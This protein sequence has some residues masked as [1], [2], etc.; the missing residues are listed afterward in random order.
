MKHDY[1]PPWNPNVV[2]W[3]TDRDEDG[4]AEVGA[5]CTVCKNSFKRKC[6]SGLMRQH[7]AQFAL[8]HVHR[9]PLDPMPKVSP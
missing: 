2:G 1:S 5:Q 4:E 6:T 7:I 9:G 3:H 8:A